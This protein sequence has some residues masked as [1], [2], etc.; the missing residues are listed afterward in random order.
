[1]SVRCVSD[2]ADEADD[3][4]ADE[5]RGELGPPVELRVLLTGVVLRGARVEQGCRRGD[6]R[7]RS[8]PGSVPCHQAL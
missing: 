4:V 2:E 6:L 7:R 1:M 3:R 8:R 5:A